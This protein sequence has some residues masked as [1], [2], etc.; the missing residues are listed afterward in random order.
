MSKKDFEVFLQKQEATQKEERKID[1]NKRKEDWIGYIDEFY[2]KVEQWLE[3]YAKQNKV[4]IHFERTTL[5]E[6]FIGSYDTRILHLKMANHVVVFSPIGTLLIGA[7]GR[8]DMEGTAGKA[9]FVL[10]AKDSTG[11]STSVITFRDAQYE[12]VNEHEQEIEW[13]WKIA[14]PPPKIRYIELNEES[15]FDALMEVVNG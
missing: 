13:T 8:I 12:E 6:G 1:W 11:I 14:T 7:H 3:D 5:N 4:A 15:F 10:V 9:Q 2:E